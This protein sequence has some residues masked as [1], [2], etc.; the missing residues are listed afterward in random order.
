LL[1]S[2]FPVKTPLECV[3]LFKKMND[4]GDGVR[5]SLIPEQLID[6]IIYRRPFAL[7]GW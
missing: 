2:D 1:G 7:F 4:W 3:T 5:L 6:D